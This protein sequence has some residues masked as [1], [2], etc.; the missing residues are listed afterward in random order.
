MLELWLITAAVAG[1][2]TWWV[3]VLAR[4]TAAGRGWA[5]LSGLPGLAWAAGTAGSVFFLWRAF[6]A[7]GQLPPDR[8][9]QHLAENLAWASWLAAG[10]CGLFLLLA[11]A[12]GLVHLRLRKKPGNA[13]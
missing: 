4:R 5:M 6:E 12:L 11:V 13:P 7:L 1:A 10:E 8:K 2:L 9:A 3:R